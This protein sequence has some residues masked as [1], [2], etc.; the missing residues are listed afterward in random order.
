M[1]FYMKKHDSINKIIIIILTVFIYL[2]GFNSTQTV[3]AANLKYFDNSSGSFCTYTGNQIT[4]TYNN[5][6]VPLSQPG[7]LINGTALADYKELFS[8]ELGITSYQAGNDIIF[9]NN[10]TNVLVSLYS[11]TAWVN[12]TEKAMSVTPVIVQV[13]DEIRYYVPTRFIAETFGFDYLWVSASNTVKISKVSSYTINNDIITYNETYYKLKYNNNVIATEMPTL[14]YNGAVIFPL[15]QVTESIGCSYFENDQSISITKNNLNLV[16]DKNSKNTYLNS[17]KIIAE[18]IPVIVTDNANGKQQTYASL[19]LIMN[20]L[21]FDCIYDVI[22]KTYIITETSNT[23]IYSPYMFYGNSASLN[24]I[25]FE[26]LSENNIFPEEK[27][28]T[29]IKAYPEENYD[30]VELHGISSADIND[31]FDNGMI[32]FEIND[33]KNDLG[34][35]FYSDYNT[36]HLNYTL[37][38]DVNDSTRLHFMAGPDDKWKIEDA[39]SF[40]KV[41]FYNENQEYIPSQSKIN[42]YPDDKLIIP[43]EEYINTD[44]ITDKDNYLE[45]NF[46]ISIKGNHVAFLED[47]NIFNPYY[48]VIKTEV[49]YDPLLDKTI[50]KIFTNS[51]SAYSYTLESGYISVSVGRPKDFYSKIIVLDAGHGGIDPGASKNGTKEKDLNFKILNTYTKDLFALSDVKVYFT[52][53]TDVKIDLYER[54]AFASKINADMFISLHMNSN[55]SSKINGTEVFYSADNNNTSSTG[56]NSAELA[57]VLANNISTAINTKNRGATKSEFVVAKYNTVPA[58]LIELGYMTNASELE[59]LKNTEYQRKT[60][61]TI[62]NTV[63]DLFNHYFLR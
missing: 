63:L 38:T 36:E 54:A 60:A 25:Y 46:E 42:Y 3:Y 49:K 23:G 57:K 44:D 53:E 52:R 28:L 4:Y 14:N 5:Y 56:F 1:R 26:W 48:G 32:V 43:V 30:V 27:T 20:M 34:T 59:K 58:V 13:G 35:N 11:K 12:G 33:I 29:K 55:N 50:V 62:Y 37:L 2:L 31:F 41:I 45:K 61:E 24:T 39:N 10:T 17:S 16:L 47:N 8:N 6:K 40:V 15:Q 19:E 22:S 51:I 9:S 18:D 7:I 21:G